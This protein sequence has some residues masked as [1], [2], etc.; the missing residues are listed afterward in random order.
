[1]LAPDSWWVA[2]I[3]SSNLPSSFGGGAAPFSSGLCAGACARA[4]VMSVSAMASEARV[5]RMG[6]EIRRLSKADKNAMT[7]T[8]G[9]FALDSTDRRGEGR[10]C[11]HPDDRGGQVAEQGGAGDAQAS[12][13]FR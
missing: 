2:A 9:P 4:G 13:A 11:S 12:C 8:G 3:Q 6:A 10:H 5:W 7:P 1:M